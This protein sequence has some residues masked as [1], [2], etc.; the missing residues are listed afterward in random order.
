MLQES[1]HSCLIWFLPSGFA[2]HFANKPTRYG[3]F[4]QH[5]EAE[6]EMIKPRLNLAFVYMSVKPKGSGLFIRLQH[7]RFIKNLLN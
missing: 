3:G 4:S 6:N 5:A 1:L 7:L 2:Q